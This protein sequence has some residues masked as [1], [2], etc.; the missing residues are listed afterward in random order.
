MTGRSNTGHLTALQTASLPICN[1]PNITL[2]SWAIWPDE[3]W[4]GYCIKPSGL[5][6]NTITKVSQSAAGLHQAIVKK[7]GCLYCALRIV[8]MIV[9]T[10][11]FHISTCRVMAIQSY[12]LWTGHSQ[13]SI[14]TQLN[15]LLLFY[16]LT[17]KQNADISFYLFYYAGF[18]CVHCLPLWDYTWT[19]N[20]GTGILIYYMCKFQ[21]EN[22]TFCYIDAQNNQIFLNLCIFHLK[23]LKH[24]VCIW[25]TI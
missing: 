10:M 17:M 21:V 12:V 20:Q 6:V 1:L 18:V 4:V 22:G 23:R 15:Q 19:R 24:F 5:Y 11:T 8:G 9:W 2:C 25:H 14:H 16:S 7:M 3:I 13:V